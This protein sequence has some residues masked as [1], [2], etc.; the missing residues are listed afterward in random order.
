MKQFEIK[1]SNSEVN[2]EEAIM[3]MESRVDGI[4][5]NQSQELMWFLSHNHLFTQG[6]SASEDEILN[7]NIIKII[8]TNRGGKTTY[9]G[10][11]QRI[12]YF[13]L[14]LNNKNKDIR[15]FISIIE[16]SLISFLAHYNV[17][18]KA[19]KDRV[20]IW[21]TKSNN[22][23]FDKEKK[24]GAIGLRIKKWITYHGLS[25]NINPDLKYYNYI[26]SCGLKEYKNTSMEELGIKLEQS[27]FDNKFKKIF[28]EKL[29]TI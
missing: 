15:K 24:I 19:F 29:K 14:N 6:T 7:T 16:N 20:G 13:M 28:L 18:A 2:Y 17:E 12:V 22:I 4:S 5:K 9:H 8:K 26:H 21:V 11:G 23:T 10:P 3:Y 25:F 27:E 1:I